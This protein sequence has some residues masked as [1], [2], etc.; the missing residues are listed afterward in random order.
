MS[1][2][3]DLGTSTLDQE[4]EMG[5]QVVMGTVGKRIN[6]GKGLETGDSPRLGVTGFLSEEVTVEKPQPLGKL[7]CAKIMGRVLQAGAPAKAKSQ[8]CTWGEADPC[9][10]GGRR[11][12][13]CGSWSRA[14]SRK[15]RAPRFQDDSVC[16]MENR[17]KVVR[18]EPVGAEPGLDT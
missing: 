15:W 1:S 5:C 8:K 7:D 6:P 12:L 18:V 2:L 11:P 10:W 16:G 4:I 17:Q 14:L 9:G 13:F 3:T